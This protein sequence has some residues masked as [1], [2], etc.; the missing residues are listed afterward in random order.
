M[1]SPVVVIHASLTPKVRRMCRVLFRVFRGLINPKL[2][3]SLTM[4][5]SVALDTCT[6]RLPKS[7]APRYYWWP[8]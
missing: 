4:P 2:T 7:L 8:S 3:M 6:F 1:T 5:A